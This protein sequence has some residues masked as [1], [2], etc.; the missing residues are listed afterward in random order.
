MLNFSCE[1]YSFFGITQAYVSV[2]QSEQS[3]DG[4][5][6]KSSKKHKSSKEEVDPVLQYPISIIYTYII[7][8]MQS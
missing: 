5:K 3:D 6:E 2:V 4:K 8:S 7:I 1:H